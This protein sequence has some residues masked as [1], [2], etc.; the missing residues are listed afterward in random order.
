M[1]QNETKDAEAAFLDAANRRAQWMD[2]AFSELLPLGPDHAAWKNHL[3]GCDH[4]ITLEQ[5]QCVEAILRMTQLKMHFG[6]IA[7]FIILAAPTLF[8]SP[9]GV[10]LPIDKKARK[11][12]VQFERKYGGLVYA[13]IREATRF[14][15]LDS[16]LY[17]SKTP[18]EWEMERKDLADWI[19]LTYTVNQSEPL[20]SEFGSIGL[21]LAESGCLI[22][23]A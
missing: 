20:F 1:E 21:R 11:E 17:V 3:K 15:R 23:T 18:S 19:P 16:L 13:V 4:S 6:A 7:N 2:S 12:I 14:G 8:F 22:R 9:Q 5:K 10:C